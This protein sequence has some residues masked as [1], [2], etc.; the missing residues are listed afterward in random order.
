MPPADRIAAFD[1][2]GTQWVEQ[3]LPQFDFVFGK[4][5]QF[6]FGK[7]AQEVKEDPALKQQQPYRA[8]F[9]RDPAFFQCVATQESA[10][11]SRSTP[12][13]GL[14]RDLRTEPDRRNYT[15]HLTVG[16]ATVPDLKALQAEPFDEF[17][18]HQSAW[19]SITSAT[20]EPPAAGSGT[21]HSPPEAKPTPTIAASWPAA[22][23]I[24][25]A[26]RVT[27]LATT[28]AP[29]TAAPRK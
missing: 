1:N 7:W 24:V 6:V 27:Q 4:W 2:D 16:F 9:E 25:H 22:K 8:I 5:S 15:A 23:D 26:A 3:P 19:P 13:Q 29:T 20:T 12:N 10:P 18:V 17:D 21:C 11:A 14:G 28:L